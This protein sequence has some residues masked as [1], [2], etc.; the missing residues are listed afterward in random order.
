MDRLEALVE[1]FIEGTTNRP[2]PEAPDIKAEV[3]AAVR[4]VQK[5]DKDKEAKAAEQQ[6]IQDQIAELKAA[7]EKPPQEFRRVTER[8]G[9]AKP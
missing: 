6:S 2:E 8:M 4:E 9:W 1:R 3:R 7:V 5:S